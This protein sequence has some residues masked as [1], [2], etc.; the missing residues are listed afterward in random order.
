MF[1][2]TAKIIELA[3]KENSILR[4]AILE[5]ERKSYQ[6]ARTHNDEFMNNWVTGN[7]DY[8]FTP[9]DRRSRLIWALNAFSKSGNDSGAEKIEAALGKVNL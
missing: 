5:K 4:Q 6:D 1:R 9:T 7:A 2:L 3:G 8:L